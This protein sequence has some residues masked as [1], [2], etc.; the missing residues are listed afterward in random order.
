[1]AR[2]HMF[3]SSGKQNKDVLPTEEPP[4]VPTSV[5][6]TTAEES[7]LDVTAADAQSPKQNS[8]LSPLHHTESAALTAALL[9]KASSDLVVAG[10]VA[11]VLSGKPDI[12]NDTSSQQQLLSSLQQNQEEKSRQDGTYNFQ[13]NEASNKTNTQPINM[14]TVGSSVKSETTTEFMDQAAAATALQLLGLA[15]Q[16]NMNSANNSPLKANTAL[17]NPTRQADS[18]IELAYTS[19]TNQYQVPSEGDIM[20]TANYPSLSSPN[21]AQ[22]T[23]TETPTEEL[24]Q[25]RG[26]WTREEDDLLLA[27]IKRFGY[28]RWK[29]IASIIPGRKGKQLKQR[30]DNTL[31]A[32]YVDQEWLQNKI[33][34]EGGINSI[35]S[36]TPTSVISR[37]NKSKTQASLQPGKSTSLALTAPELTDWTVIAQKISEKLKDGDHG[38]LEALIS[39]ALINSLQASSAATPSTATNSVNTNV[40]SLLNYP[41][42]ALLLFPQQLQ[43]QQKLQQKQSQ[44]Q[45]TE[46][47]TSGV[48]SSNFYITALQQQQQQQ[49]QSQPVPA[50]SA[51]VS[52]KRRRSDPALANTQ[53]DA[54]NI[55]ASAQPITTTINN[56]TQTYYPCLFP[57]CDHSFAAFATLPLAETMTLKDM[58]KS[59][60]VTNLTGAQAVAKVFQDWTL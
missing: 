25:K 50:V 36:S 26:A 49:Q 10:A 17:P 45:S 11:A 20:V 13:Q 58:G 46:A 19:S 27:G 21:T 56:Q 42:P 2:V 30:W 29:E 60:V 54:M 35:Q 43:Q 52:K 4:A 53:S 32:K 6:N 38:A 57:D 28:G 16:S 39:Q 33:K 44:E 3:K 1:M 15:Q 8:T 31:A 37:A 40:P 41:D 48:D 5:D 24:N 59:M 9:Q 51:Q 7:S 34:D 18:S 12:L 14:C 47:I 22:S 55:Y 23:S